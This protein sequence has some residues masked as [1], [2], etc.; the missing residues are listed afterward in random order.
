M[1]KKNEEKIGC[2][3]CENNGVIKRVKKGKE[4]KNVGLRRKERKGLVKRKENT[5]GKLNEL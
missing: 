3:S 1:T 5:V 2:K 4:K